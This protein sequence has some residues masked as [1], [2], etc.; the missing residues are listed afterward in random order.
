MNLA[1]C[2]RILELSADADRQA[3][4]ASYRRLARQYHPDVNPGNPE[5]AHAKFV[6]LTAAYNF[7]LARV[8]ETTEIPSSVEP[9]ASGTPVKTAVK[10]TVKTQ[11]KQRQNQAPPPPQPEP[12]KSAH[13]QKL[14]WDSFQLLQQLFKKHSYLRAISLAE[15]LAQRFIGDREVQQWQAIAYQQYGRHLM[16]KGELEKARVFLKKALRTDPHNRTLWSQVEQDFR[17]IEQML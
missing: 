14:K 9:P 7:L 17:Q 6:E 16:T 4:K 3:I 1:E 5:Q 12:P 8:G 13:E 10:T 15:S 2:Y 11:V